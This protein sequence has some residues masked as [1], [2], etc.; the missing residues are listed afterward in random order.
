MMRSLLFFSLIGIVLATSCANDE[1]SAPLPE[2]S[3]IDSTSVASRPFGYNVLSYEGSVSSI[4]PASIFF[5]EGA[6][7][8]FGLPLAGSTEGFIGPYLLTEKRGT[9]VSNSITRLSLWQLEEGV[10]S[11][12]F[13]IAQQMN[14]GAGKLEIVASD[15]HLEIQQSL[16]FVD[17]NLAEIWLTIENQG[18]DSAYVMPSWTGQLSSPGA[19]T[20]SDGRAVSFSLPSGENHLWIGS[21]ELDSLR[22]DS[23]DQSYALFQ[24]L[25]AIAPGEA[26]GWRIF[27]ANGPDL[28][29]LSSVLGSYAWQRTEA[30]REAVQKRWQ[31]LSDRAL[32][33]L[34]DTSNESARLA[35][36]CVETLI[37]NWRSPAG[38]LTHSGLFPSYRYRGFHGFWSWDSWKHAVALASL[39][40]E[41]AKEQVRAMFAYQ[42][43]AG[44]IA[45]CIFRDPA[46][47]AHNWRDTKPPLATWAVLEIFE[48]SHDTAF[49]EELYPALVRYHRWWY[50]ERDH[51]QNGLCEF[52]STDGTLVA[53]KWESGMDNAVR[54][55]QSELL[56]NSASA[57]SLNQ[58]SVDLNSYLCL[59][60]QQLAT[61]ATVL[62]RE[63]DKETFE[64]EAQQLKSR[65]QTAFYD[66]ESGWFYDFS[67]PGD[68]LIKVQGPEGWTPLWVGLAT[69]EQAERIRNGIM[70]PSKFNTHVPCPTLAADHPKFDP[71]DGYW[72]GPVWLDQAYFAIEGLKS[73]GYHEEAQLLRQKLLE[74]ASGLHDQSPIRENYHPVTGEGLNAEHFSWSAAHLW[75]LLQK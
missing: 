72:R 64:T 21:F 46:V 58:E 5:D 1:S 54:F 69:S 16:S 56:Q 43:E 55:D 52:G 60:K 31:T 74:H 19:T 41:L 73:Y 50:Q 40:P 15:D 23:I 57:W 71:L 70:D 35:Q 48:A 66:E 6:W 2:A 75:L 37:N 49:V 67:I 10:L 59:E 22:I 63:E 47:E 27:V 20:T 8:G 45:D 39:K 34:S 7:F 44:M 51:N 42:N 9:H 18:E 36:K 53:A 62:A 12:S 13:P 3:E 33:G 14:G 11:E 30:T 38:E 24:P 28:D 32:S 61:L 68:S 4:A 25:M 17:A 65:I 26:D 29:T